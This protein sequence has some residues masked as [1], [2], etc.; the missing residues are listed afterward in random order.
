MADVFTNDLTQPGTSMV[1]RLTLH[2]PTER[3]IARLVADVAEDEEYDLAA[4]FDEVAVNSFLALELLIAIEEKFGCQFSPDEFLDN[5]SIAGLAALVDRE[6]SRTEARRIIPLR[7]GTGG[8]VLFLAHSIHGSNVYFNA[9]LKRID[10][11]ISVYGLLW[12]RSKSGESM[13]AE[14]HAAAYLPMVRAVQPSGPYCLAGHS[15]G[16][17]LALELAQQLFEGGEHVAFL[18]MLDDEIDFTERRFD[19]RRLVPAESTTEHTKHMLGG[20]VPVAYPGNVWLYRSAESH[21]DCLP[22]PNLG[23][24]DIACGML[25]QLVVPG[26]HD[27]MVGKRLVGHW[28]GSFQESMRAAW[29]AARNAQGNTAEAM[30][31]RAREKRRRLDVRA[32]TSA[33][34][35]AKNGDLA[36]EIAHYRAAIA[37]DPEEQ[38]FWVYRNLGEAL[39]QGGDPAG[40]I[41]AYRAAA[42]REAIPIFGYSLL[43][44]ALRRAGHYTEAEEAFVKAESF[45]SE[46]PL[47][48]QALVRLDHRRGRPDGAEARLRR[49]MAATASEWSYRRLAALL[50]NQGRLD[51]AIKLAGEACSRFPLQPYLWAELDALKNRQAA[52]G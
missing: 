8:P 39:A 24:R 40:S 34:H 29:N 18:G 23:W 44:A 50:G 27:S 45:E 17:H 32:A 4:Q 41:D 51:E 42:D 22:D 48:Q 7:T 15:F 10:P 1:P 19:I 25:H 16:G 3:E 31:E 2:T 52:A 11:D 36:G 5:L 33:R 20:Y 13:T 47:V 35:A 46:D 26:N 6:R 49:L 9:A 14:R 30:L 38:P 12:E 21:Y 28:I 37:H 43:G